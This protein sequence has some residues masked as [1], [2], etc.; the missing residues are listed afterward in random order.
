[1][2]IINKEFFYLHDSTSYE[3]R[4]A[5][6]IMQLNTGD[7]VFLENEYW[8]IEFKHSLQDVDKFIPPVIMERIINGDIHLMLCNSHEAFHS[9]VKEIYL[10]VI[11]QLGVP[12]N[13]VT[14]LSESADINQEIHNVAK[15]AGREQISSAWTRIFE[16]ACMCHLTYNRS[17]DFM[18]LPI[19]VDKVYDKKFLNFNRRWRLHRPALVALMHVRGILSRGH[20]SLAP[21]DDNN[22][23]ASVW[24]WMKS[25]HQG[26][27]EITSI[28]IAN[29]EGILK[30]P[31]MYLDT[32]ELITNRA[33]L[34]SRADYLYSDTYFSVVS[35]TNF[36]DFSPGRFLSEKIFKPVAMG[37]PFI[38]LSRPNSLQL[39]RRL[40]Y[41]TFSPWIDESY[42]QEEDDNRRLLMILNEIERL[43]NLTP[44]ELTDFLNGVRDICLFNRRILKSKRAFYN[45]LPKYP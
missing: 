7:P 26:N 12:P 43:S 21:C 10:R 45:I 29:E 11:D 22:D 28:L 37:H 4:P 2:S 35:E 25:Q 34:E 13:K 36:Y 38:L 19:L 16:H 42:D 30:I 3:F 9:V 23:W 44:N 39:L 14:L 15:D 18:Q 40:S 20:V 27:D 6:G 5:S 17:I 24:E 31:P 33:E 32:D 41:Q 1:M 8:Y